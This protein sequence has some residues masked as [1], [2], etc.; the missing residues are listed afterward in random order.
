MRLKLRLSI[1]LAV[2]G[3]LLLPALVG[4]LLT[5]NYQERALA[6]RLVADHA[7]ITEIL[8]L[9]IEESLW[10]VSPDVARPLFDS[11]LG[12]ERVVSALVRDAKFG[13]FLS[14]EYPERRKGRQFKLRH[15]VLRSGIVIGDVQVEMDSGQFQAEVAD[16]RAIFALTVLGQL[17]LSV[18]LIVALLNVRLLKPIRRLMRES[19]RLARRDLAE[20][21]VWHRDDELGTLGSGLER[22]RQALRALFDELEAKNRQLEDDIAQRIRIEEELKRF[23]PVPQKW[24]P[25][26]A[27]SFSCRIPVPRQTLVA[28]ATQ[29]ALMFATWLRLGAERFLG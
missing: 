18:L 29:L 17:L 21:F 12:D 3:G 25:A 4:S 26:S 16:S 19:D 10:N 9:G 6:S 28:A 8:A 1:V 13:V 2:V 5:L 14:R 20:P 24:A 27:S 23:R 11:V 22:T 7:R 15:D